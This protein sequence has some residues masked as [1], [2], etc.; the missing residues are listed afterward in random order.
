MA[1]HEFN[2]N[3]GV[4]PGPHTSCASLCGHEDSQMLSKITTKTENQHPTT[5][6]LAYCSLRFRTTVGGCSI[7]LTIVTARC[8][9]N[10][11]LERKLVDWDSKA[12]PGVQAAARAQEAPRLCT[13]RL[14]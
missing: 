13:L 2:P 10:V 11:I 3:R 14:P 9:R 12:N 6:R 7:I 1:G 4:K 8:W 5:N